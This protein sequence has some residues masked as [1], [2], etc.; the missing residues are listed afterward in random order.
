MGVPL[1]VLVRKDRSPNNV[2]TA[3]NAVIDSLLKSTT[4]DKMIFRSPGNFAESVQIR[5]VFENP[6]IFMNQ[7]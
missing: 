7:N 5:N 2:P 3:V 6:G 4:K 1:E